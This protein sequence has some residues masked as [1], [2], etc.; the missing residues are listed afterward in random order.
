PAPPPPYTLSLHDALPILPRVDLQLDVLIGLRGRQRL[1]DAVVVVVETFADLI[2][3]FLGGAHRAQ[4][5]A[6]IEPEKP[7]LSGQPPQKIR[8]EEHTSELQSRRDLVCR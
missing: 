3:N 5:A 7:V 1:L 6:D 4:V 2:G 8:S